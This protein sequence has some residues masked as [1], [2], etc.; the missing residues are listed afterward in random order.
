M[1]HIPINYTTLISE[2]KNIPRNGCGDSW[3]RWR[4]E[5]DLGRSALTSF[6][7]FM[8]WLQ[9][10]LKKRQKKMKNSGTMVDVGW[11]KL[12]ARIICAVCLAADQIWVWE[13][14]DLVSLT[15][16]SLSCVENLIRPLWWESQAGMGDDECEITSWWVW[17]SLTCLRRVPCIM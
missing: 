4:W 6:F 14:E 8:L 11:W 9:V 7:F 15:Y 16:I 17:V 10:S 12:I 13:H 5:G 2:I 3:E 1:A